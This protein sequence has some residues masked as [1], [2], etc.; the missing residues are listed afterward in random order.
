[1]APGGA[2]GLTAKMRRRVEQAD[3]ICGGQKLLDMFPSLTGEKIPIGKNLTKIADLIKK[4]QGQKRVVVL[5]SGDP[6]FFGIAGYLTD[7]LGKGSIKIMPNVSA[8]QLAFARIGE[9]WDDATFVSVH[10]RPIEDII[11]KVWNGDKIGIFTDGEHT[12]AAIA[13]VLLDSGINGYRAYVCENLGEKT[14]RIIKTSLKGLCKREFSPLNTLI[15]LRDKSKPA[16]LISPRT[17]GIPDKEFY[18]RRPKEGLITKQEIRAISL[19]KMQIAEN[20]IVWDIGAGSGSVSIEAD[21]L[22]PNGRVFA[23]ERKCKCGIGDVL[24]TEEFPVA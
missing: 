13:R 4:N 11:A 17:L 20:N 1:M 12:P 16:G 24:A 8:M 21:H 5:A 18:K 15:L 14:E 19:A 10:A 3:I 2:A 23:V 22:M 9:S 7:A 6:G